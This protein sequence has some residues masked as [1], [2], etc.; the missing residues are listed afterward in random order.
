[1]EEWVSGGEE[2]AS[3]GKGTTYIHGWAGKPVEGAD[4]RANVGGGGGG[5]CAAAAAAVLLLTLLLVAPGGRVRRHG[6]EA[7][8]SAAARRS[9]GAGGDAAA[10]AEAAEAA[11][12]SAA[13]RCCRWCWRCCRRW[14]SCWRWRWRRRALRWRVDL[15]SC[16][17]SRSFRPTRSWPASPP[18]GETSPAPQQTLRDARGQTGGEGAAARNGG[19]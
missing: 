10:A 9:R 4:T 17:S 5:G 2:A 1:M 8:R 15:R 14:C 18:P 16:A 6:Q 11:E 7:R 13:G 12:A 3:V 19:V